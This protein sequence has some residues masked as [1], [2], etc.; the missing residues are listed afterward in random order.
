MIGVG[1][2]IRA[3]EGELVDDGTDD[4]VPRMARN[5]PVW[6]S[7]RT[8]VVKVR[9]SAVSLPIVAASTGTAFRRPRTYRNSTRAWRR[10]AAIAMKTGS[11]PGGRSY[12]RKTHRSMAN[13]AA[14]FVF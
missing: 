14:V 13:A 1:R 12:S 3:E 7:S 10:S 8:P 11:V 9:L 2:V 5:E 4:G 6:S